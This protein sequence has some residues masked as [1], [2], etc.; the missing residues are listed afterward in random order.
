MYMVSLF[1]LQTKLYVY[2]AVVQL[3][4]LKPWNHVVKRTPQLNGII[5]NDRCIR[6]GI[7]M[8]QCALVDIER[9]TQTNR[10]D[11]S[12]AA[13]QRWH[14]AKIQDDKKTGRSIWMSYSLYKCMHYSGCMHSSSWDFERHKSAM[15][16]VR[17][18]VAFVWFFFDDKYK[19]TVLWFFLLD[20]MWNKNFS[21]QFKN[22]RGQKSFW[23]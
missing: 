20:F 22:K 5:T 19:G 17:S 12:M 7:S 10:A 13:W 3:T 14:Q 16:A 15:L 6:Y 23:E 9:I 21:K 1:T 8:N 18:F 2:R 4:Q 11:V